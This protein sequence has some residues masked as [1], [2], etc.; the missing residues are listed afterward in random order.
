MGS[1]R[2]HQGPK[3]SVFGWWICLSRRE[4]NST[5]K[6]MGWEILWLVREQ[7]R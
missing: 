2:R 3:S 6:C 5:T 1:C 4:K 7:M